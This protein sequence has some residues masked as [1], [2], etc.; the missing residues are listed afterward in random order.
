MLEVEFTGQRVAV[1]PPGVA[2]TCLRPKN[3][4]REYLENQGRQSRDY[5]TDR[6]PF[7]GLFFHTTWASRHQSGF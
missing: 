3:W 5:Y 4:R 7:N 1:W 6:C 2:K